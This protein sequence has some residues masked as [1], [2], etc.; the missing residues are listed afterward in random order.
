MTAPELRPGGG[1]EGRRPVGPDALAALVR[2]AAAHTRVDCAQHL[3]EA[4]SHG[5]H[6]RDAMRA[7]AEWDAQNPT[8]RIGG[9]Q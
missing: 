9:T 1:G 3:L 6:C 7:L 4:V 2:A 8:Q 5:L